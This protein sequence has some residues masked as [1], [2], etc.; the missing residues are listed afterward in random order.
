MPV[1]MGGQVAQPAGQ[2][3]VALTSGRQDMSDVK[4]RAGAPRVSDTELL[5]CE[6]LQVLQQPLGSRATQGPRRGY[7]RSVAGSDG[8]ISTTI[9]AD[10]SGMGEATANGAAM[11][12]IKEAGVAAVPG[13]AF[14]SGTAGET[15]EAVVRVFVDAGF[16]PAGLL[17]LRS[18]AAGPLSLRRWRGTRAARF[19]WGRSSRGKGRSADEDLRPFVQP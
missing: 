17:V 18:I 15:G 5:Y 12:L 10:V 11:R 14:F 3:T 4:R 8:Y 7:A 9:L 2:W 13:T 6:V 16:R 1:G 19:F